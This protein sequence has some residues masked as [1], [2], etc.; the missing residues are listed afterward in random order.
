MAADCDT[1]YYLVVTKV[2]ERLA[3]SKQITHS[4]YKEVQPQEIK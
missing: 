1:D 3:V 2:G 4:S